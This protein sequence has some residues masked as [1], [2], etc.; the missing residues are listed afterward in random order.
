[1]LEIGSVAPDFTLLD[2]DGREVSLHDFR[3]KWVVL[4]WFPKASTPG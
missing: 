4:W 3:G 1:M 2:Q